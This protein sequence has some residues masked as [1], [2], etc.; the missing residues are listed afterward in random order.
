MGVPIQVARLLLEESKARP[1]AG[2][3]LTLGRTSVYVTEAELRRF[4][5]RHGVRLADDGGPI[6][7]S[8][9]PEL[10]ACGCLGDRSFFRLLGFSEVTSVDASN[11][12][13]ADR[14]A[15]LNRSLPEEM[16]GRFD[17]VFEA[18][19]IQHVFHLPNVFANLHAVL[20]PGGRA[21]H[22]MAPS[23]NHVDHGFHQFSPTLF[24]D[25]YAANGWRLE[26]E[27]LCEFTSL[28]LGSRF[29]PAGFTVRRYRPGCLDELAYGGFRARQLAL[30]VVASKV[31]HATADVAPQQGYYRSFWSDVSE[32]ERTAGRGGG[33]SRRRSFDRLTARWP[34]IEPPLLG[35][36]R[37][38]RL[39][40]RLRPRRLPPVT[41]RY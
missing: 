36:K 28:W 14:I 13:G 15:D 29:R 8:H 10:A 26:S 17:A 18:G 37:L 20:K 25:Y 32:R 7:L 6:G 9:N 5:R 30:F 3:L 11:W 2:S 35:W 1:F 21:I 16:R 22:G 19:T 39:V 27:L 34:W 33:P 4:A 24:H 12:E 31:E 23:H 40:G 41:A 38:R